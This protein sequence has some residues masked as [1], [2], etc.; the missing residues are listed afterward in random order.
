MRSLGQERHVV[1]TKVAGD[2]VETAVGGVVDE[3]RAGSVDAPP[4]AFVAADAAR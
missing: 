4:A 2:E 3:E 1:A